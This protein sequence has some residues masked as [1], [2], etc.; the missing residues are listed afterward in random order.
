M[1]SRQQLHGT[2]PSWEPD[3]W[4]PSNNGIGGLKIHYRSHY[5]PLLDPSCKQAEFS[6]NYHTTLLQNHS[7]TSRGMPRAIVWAVHDW[8]WYVRIKS[9]SKSR[10][11]FFR[12][13]DMVKMSLAPPR[14]HD[15]TKTTDVRFRNIAQARLVQACI[16]T[17][18]SIFKPLLQLFEH[19]KASHVS[20]VLNPKTIMI[21]RRGLQ[22][23]IHYYKI[24]VN[25][26][27]SRQGSSC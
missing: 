3:D 22:R 5:S 15:M 19:T 7:N 20:G 27:Q 21:R 16:I 1:H 24:W 2:A 11:A 17:T 25:W 10:L 23:T 8:L 12:S 18:H 4:S 13:L 9:S 26:S 6:T 14:T